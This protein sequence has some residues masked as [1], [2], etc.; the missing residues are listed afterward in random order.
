MTTTILKHD[1][2]HTNVSIVNCKIILILYIILNLSTPSNE[3]GPSIDT[4]YYVIIIPNAFFLRFSGSL[5]QF[6]SNTQLDS[7][8]RYFK[9]ETFILHFL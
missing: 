2:N 5:E 8:N 6:T 9:S 3:E 1:S 4:L 7:C